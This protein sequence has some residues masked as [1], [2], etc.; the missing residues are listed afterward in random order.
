MTVITRFAPSPTGYLH[1]GGARTALFNWLFAR[2]YGGKFLLRIEDTDRARSTDDAINAILKG[3][4]WLGLDWDEE[5]VFQFSRASRH[6]EV[7]EAMVKSGHAYYCYCSAEELEQMKQQAAAE[8]RP[9]VYDGRWRDRDTSE[10]PKDIKPVIRMKMPKDGETVIHDTVQGIVTVHNNQLDDM[11]LLRSDG[12]PTYMLAVVVDDHDMGI[13]HI[14]RGDDHLTNAFRQKQIYEAMGWHVPS[15]SHI[16]LIHGQDGAK[17]SKRHG[18]LGVEAYDAMGFL[19]EAMRNYLVRLSWAHGDDEIFSTQQAIEWFDGTSI[20]KSA[21]RFDM[22]KLTSL[23]GHYIQESSNDRLVYLLKEQYPDLTAE[24]LYRIQHG[25]EGLKKRAKTLIELWENAQIYVWDVPNIYTEKAKSFLMD[26]AL[27]QQLWNSMAEVN[28]WEEGPLHDWAKQ[29]SESNNIKL[30]DI[31][32]P[33]RAAL[34]GSTVSPSVFEIAAV[35]GKDLT[36]KRFQQAL[37]LN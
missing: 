11:I 18:A 34:T 19:P 2:H 9:P 1:I 15:F 28:V 20:G 14:I 13:T 6:I 24:Q 29:F 37:D 10:A 17:L 12:T 30:G 25:M 16:P 4:T 7:A 8:G 31:A 21:A 32:Q 22:V 35:I 36:E 23:N 26:K 3:L 27:L 5:P 33:I